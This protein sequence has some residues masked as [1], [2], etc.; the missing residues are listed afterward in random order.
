MTG[1]L[2][3]SA[4]VHDL[5]DAIR[6]RDIV[7]SDID[8]DRSTTS[9]Q[10]AGWFICV[11]LR[12]GSCLA[13]CVRYFRVYDVSGLATSSRIYRVLISTLGLLVTPSR[14]T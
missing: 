1:W 2:F 5:H 10:L 12:L 13:R 4:I 6:L 14:L 7:N 11:P 8:V 3:N 9:P